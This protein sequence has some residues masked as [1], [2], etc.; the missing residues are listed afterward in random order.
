MKVSI[1]KCIYCKFLESINKKENTL[2]CILE[3]GETLSLPILIDAATIQKVVDCP[4]EDNTVKIKVVKDNDGIEMPFY[5]TPSSSGFDLIASEMVLLKPDE[6]KLIPTGLR[7]E[8]PDGY[9][10]QIRPRSGISLKTS[11]IM[12]DSPGTI[13]ADY[14]GEI[15]IILWNT[16]NKESYTV[17]KGDRIAQGV[18]IKIERAEFVVVDELTKTI[19]QEG[20]FGHTGYCV[21]EA[22]FCQKR[23]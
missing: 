16:S 22:N 7:F 5:A 10:L 4:R 23:D 21:K 3:N 13:D 17:N 1:C 12:P 20:G 6:R 14:R 18:L 8:I 15:Q 9:E 11:I 2:S 19:R